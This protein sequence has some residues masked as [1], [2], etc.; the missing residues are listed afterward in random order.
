LYDDLP[1]RP[2]T[3]T[4]W[5]VGLAGGLGIDVALSQN[6]FLRA[7]WQYVRFTDFAGAA[8]SIN[9]LRAGAGLKF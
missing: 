9:T 1:R 2:N 8:A 6:A 7:E 3:R 4:A 5:S